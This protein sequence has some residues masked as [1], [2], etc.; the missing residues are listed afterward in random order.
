VCHAYRILTRNG[1]PHDNIITMVLLRLPLLRLPL[2]RLLLLRLLFV[3][4]LFVGLLRLLFVVPRLLFATV[5]LLI[6]IMV[7]EFTKYLSCVDVRRRGG[8]CGQSISG[9][10]I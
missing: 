6:D 2:L 10:V 5:C 3:G 1:V 8:R 7:C 4:L 9:T